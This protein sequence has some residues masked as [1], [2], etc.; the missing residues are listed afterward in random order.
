MGGDC[1]AGRRGGGMTIDPAA[2]VQQYRAG[3]EAEISVLGRL[4]DLSK[5][6]HDASSASDFPSL[7]AASEERDRLM[8]GL[9][10]V[11]EGVRVLREALADVQAE[12]VDD[13]AFQQTIHLHRAVVAMVKRI[14]GTD[15]DSLAALATAETA[16]R[17]AVRALE[18]GEVTL[19]AYRRLAATP[20]PATLLNRRG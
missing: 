12:L 15:Q 3:L 4:E 16:R 1:G 8:A 19:E 18:R 14:L 5:R 6:Q 13:P 17:E 2:L 20:L 7:A 10:E 11:E 9:V